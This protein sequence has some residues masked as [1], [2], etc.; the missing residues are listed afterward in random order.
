MQKHAERFID[1]LFKSR[2]LSLP[3][4]AVLMDH[5]IFHGSE[6]SIETAHVE[7]Q[8][9]LKFWLEEDP[10]ILAGEG[11][12]LENFAS[13]WRCYRLQHEHEVFTTHED[14]RYVV[15]VMI[16]GDEGRSV[17]K[18]PY[19]IC[20]MESPIGGTP[21]TKSQGPCSCKDALGEHLPSFGVLNPDL[22][23]DDTLKSCR[24]MHTNYTGHSFLSKM[25]LFGVAGWIYKNN[26]HVVTSLLETIV[27]GFQKLFSE[28]VVAR[29]KR[30]YAAV[31]AVKGDMDF[32]LK[33]CNLER[34]YSNVGHRTLGYICHCCMAST[35]AASTCGFEDFSE[36][37]QWLLSMFRTRP[38]SSEPAFARLPYDGGKCPEKLL[39]PDPFH[40]VKLGLARDVVGGIII[41]LLRRGFFDFPH[42][43]KSLAARLARAQ[44]MFVLFAEVSKARFS[45]RGFT[46]QFFHIKN[47]LSAPWSNSKGSDSMLLLRWLC[48]FLRLNINHPTVQFEGSDSLLHS[49]LQCA[50]A[51]LQMFSLM[52]SHR[53]WLERD[54]ARLLYVRIMR[55]LR[56][57]SSLGR[58][59]MQLGIRSFILKPKSHA[60]H[61][62][63]IELRRQLLCGAPL[64]LNPESTA[65]EMNEDYIG[66]VA[67]LSRR[68][69][70]RVVDK[71]VISRV[72]LK[73]RDFTTKGRRITGEALSMAPADAIISS[74]MS[75]RC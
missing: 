67:R 42:K 11:D 38:W 61:H 22:L 29:G 6:K 41:I 68:V 14:L 3:I 49:M 66:R 31:I 36:E 17:K 59:A 52:H 50:E 60:L 19:L 43:S 4:D 72:L 70:A 40:V 20:S 44:S 64:V 25:L 8:S 32:H 33:F 5:E 15:P 18:S 13:F 58:K 51:I 39:V 73:Y 24:S 45:F 9:W 48:W 2:R 27:A 12:V 54:C 74:Q 10:S 53:L 57:Y 26:G 71:R 23:D 7:P 16:H 69:S 62:I 35:G 47:K 37:P 56:S 34:S 1:R 75:D 55:A 65:T 28:G 30:W 21:R 63:A 46:K